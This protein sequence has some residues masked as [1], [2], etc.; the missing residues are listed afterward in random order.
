MKKFLKYLSLAMSIV[1]PIVGIIYLSTSNK[2]FND[3]N[4]YNLFWLSFYGSILVCFLFKS[5][6]IRLAIVLANLAVVSVFLFGFLIKRAR[7]I[8][9][10]STSPTYSFL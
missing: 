4:I 9:F 1:V 3:F 8:N 2:F 5:K 7:W 6:L 10:C